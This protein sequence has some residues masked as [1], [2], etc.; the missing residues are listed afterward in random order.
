M[1][2]N[3]NE[4]LEQ[5]VARA[6]GFYRTKFGLTYEELAQRMR[7]VKVRVHPS[8][9]QKTEKSG[10]RPTVSELAG[11]AKV[12]GIPI[13]ELWGGRDESVGTESGWHDF[14][15][16]VRMAEVKSMVDEQY[17]QMVGEVREQLKRDIALQ[18]R[19]TDQFISHQYGFE[20]KRL[21]DALDLGIEIRNSKDFEEYLEGT[22]HPTDVDPLVHAVT[23]VIGQ[24][25]VPK[26]VMSEEEI[27]QHW[28]EKFR[29]RDGGKE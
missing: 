9:I 21:M 15:G 19:V 2:A 10:R 22:T 4:T 13:E 11:Y 16:L 23:E 6:I 7:S 28:R 24:E 20:F 3:D 17:R 1:T 14:I 18:Q 12:F 27:G 8:A 26:I 5:A 25:R 29:A